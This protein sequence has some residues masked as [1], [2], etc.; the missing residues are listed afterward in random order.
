MPLLL[1]NI[2]H[3]SSIALIDS[4]AGHYGH[5]SLFVTLASISALLLPFRVHQHSLDI[6]STYLL[7][8]LSTHFGLIACFGFDKPRALFGTARISFATTINEI[9]VCIVVSNES[10]YLVL[11]NLDR[12]IWPVDEQQQYVL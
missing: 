12:N 1:F 8:F 2:S 6:H 9:L 7:R 3:D 5:L 11:P 4:S 10:T